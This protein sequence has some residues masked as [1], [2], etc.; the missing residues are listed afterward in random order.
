MIKLSSLHVNGNIEYFMNLLFYVVLY[1][2]KQCECTTFK[3]KYE[4]MLT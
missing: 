3:S 1:I 2:H 4:V